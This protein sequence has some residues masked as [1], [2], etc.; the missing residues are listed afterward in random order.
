MLYPVA[1]EKG[2]ETTAFGA[3]FPD[4]KKKRD[5]SVSLQ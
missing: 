4:A 2:T 5:H 3:V 1:I